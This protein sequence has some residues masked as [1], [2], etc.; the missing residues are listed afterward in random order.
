MS[1]PVS[2][3]AEDKSLS[4]QSHV[5][6]EVNHICFMELLQRLSETMHMNTIA[7]SI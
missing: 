7:L 4:S 2:A 5:S 6:D 1:I 3:L